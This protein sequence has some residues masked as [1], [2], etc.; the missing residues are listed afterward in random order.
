MA[1]SEQKAAAVLELQD[2]LR[3]RVWLNCDSQIHQERHR[4]R[5][6]PSSSVATNLGGKDVLF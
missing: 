6:A 2:E 4:D 3:E 5:I 1:R